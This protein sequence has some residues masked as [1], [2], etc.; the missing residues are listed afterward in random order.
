MHSCVASMIK[1]FH[2]RRRHGSLYRTVVMYARLLA[3]SRSRCRSVA[4]NHREAE[5]LGF[6]KCINLPVM[7]V[8]TVYGHIY[9]AYYV[10]KRDE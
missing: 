2:G 10:A 8:S 1:R 5:V 6:D 3:H 9:N 7:D 4:D